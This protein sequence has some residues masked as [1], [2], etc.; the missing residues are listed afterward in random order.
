MQKQAATHL[1]WT[2]TMAVAASTG[3]PLSVATTDKLYA[4]TASKFK[5]LSDTTICPVT[6]SI[7]KG[8]ELAPPCATSME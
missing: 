7:A 4:G 1:S 2:V 8:S 5:T 6:L 3:T